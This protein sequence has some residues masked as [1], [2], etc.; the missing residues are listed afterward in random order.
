MPGQQEVRQLT[1]NSTSEDAV[2]VGN[3][4]L[5][6]KT[7]TVNFTHSG[8]W[9]S[10]FTNETISV[11]ASN[12]ATIELEPGQFF[13][14]F[15]NDRASN[16]NYTASLLGAVPNLSFASG[17]VERDT[18]KIEI[19]TSVQV[20]AQSKAKSDLKIIKDNV[21]LASNTGTTLLATLNSAIADTIS[22]SAKATRNGITYDTTAIVVFYKPL[23][24]ID[25]QLSEAI[26]LYP[27]PGTTLVNLKLPQAMRNKIKEVRVFSA[28]GGIVSSLPISYTE[29]GLNLNIERL[30]NGLYFI[31]LETSDA[32]YALKRLVKSK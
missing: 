20:T 2:L 23:G 10:Y 3:F 12:K 17:T 32:K 1:L 18:L 30:A 6:S 29:E 15:D 16:S 13:L 8:D 22:I 27:N 24:F 21:E 19:G 7:Y 25:Q 31:R 11:D 5:T 28:S 14:L 9:F 26:E 4:A